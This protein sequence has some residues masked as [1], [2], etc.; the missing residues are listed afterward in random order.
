MKMDE[1]GIEDLLCVYKVLRGRCLVIICWHTT[2][3]FQVEN[4]RQIYDDTSY[5]S[6][7]VYDVLLLYTGKRCSEQRKQ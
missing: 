1:Q 2:M 5:E 6:F 4:F 7:M 3:S